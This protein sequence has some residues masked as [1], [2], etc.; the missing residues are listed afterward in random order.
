VRPRHD[1]SPHFGRES[2][3]GSRSP[4]FAIKGFGSQHVNNFVHPDLS[5]FAIGTF[6]IACRT[7]FQHRSGTGNPFKPR[8]MPGKTAVNMSKG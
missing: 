3:A 7:E 2:A 1:I 6:A 5:P 8:G 4:D